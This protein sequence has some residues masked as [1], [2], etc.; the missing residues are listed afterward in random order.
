MIKMIKI[1]F[2]SIFIFFSL[3]GHADLL[4]GE[5]HHDSFSNAEKASELVWIVESTKVGLFSSDVYGYVLHYEY[6]GDLDKENGILRNMELVFPITSMNSD[7]ESRDEKLHNKCMGAKEF[8]SITVKI[9]GPLFLKDKREREYAGS[10]MIRGKEKSFKIKM[11]PDYDG[12][13]LIIKGN[14]TWSLKGMEIP[15]PS[16]AV[17]Q[18]SDEIRLKIKLNPSLK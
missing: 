1:L 12:E 14:T 2:T 8:K 18:L 3:A 10:V 16:I 11:S 4:K 13:K 6:K 15:D 7:S 9:P 17:A 5:V